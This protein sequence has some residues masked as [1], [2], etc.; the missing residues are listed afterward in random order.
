M[1]Y[2]LDTDI[3][4]YAL[5]AKTPAVERKLAM[6]P[7]SELAISV[8]TQGELLYG[9]KILAP[10]HRL[11]AAVRKW[12]GMVRIFS[13]D[14][15]AAEHYA[16]IRHYLT[17]TGQPIGELDMMI[18][19]HALALDATLVTNYTRHYQRIQAPLRLE[20]WSV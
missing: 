2:L 16:E 1:L 9:L 8:V 4:S 6:V 13:W 19:A 7:R 12:L 10:N 11:H 5:R 20:N 15:Q 18:A 14:S 17:A 3:M